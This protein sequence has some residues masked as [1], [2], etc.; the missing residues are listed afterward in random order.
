[1]EN[2]KEQYKKRRKELK[3]NIY[4]LSLKES[5][6]HFVISPGT[7]HFERSLLNTDAP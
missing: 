6:A 1:M 4:V 5:K 2:Y 3:L 7:D